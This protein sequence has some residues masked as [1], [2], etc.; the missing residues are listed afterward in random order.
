M[1]IKV[2]LLTEKST[3][4]AIGA[5]FYDRI[6]YKFHVSMAIISN[7]PLF[8]P[9]ESICNSFSQGV[10]NVYVFKCIVCSDYQYIDIPLGRDLTDL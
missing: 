1:M 7:P 5:A 6:R 4:M 8:C 2:S 3:N 9:R 10:C